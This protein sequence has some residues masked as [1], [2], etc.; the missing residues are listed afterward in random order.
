MH[1]EVF[2]EMADLL[3]EA[4]E[5]V[6]TISA[7]LR[8]GSQHVRGQSADLRAHSTKLIEHSTRIRER[9]HFVITPPAHLHRFDHMHNALL[10]LQAG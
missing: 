5:E 6:R 4:M 1:V 8:E 2:W 10:F 3:Q 7:T 9:M